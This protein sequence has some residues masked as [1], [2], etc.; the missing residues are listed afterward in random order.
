MALLDNY[1]KKQEKRDQTAAE[2]ERPTA[3]ELHRKALSI[4]G[5]LQ[6]YKW[7]EKDEDSQKK[8]VKD[9]ANERLG[10]GS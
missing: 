4:L 9:D 3:E 1:V 8:K 5:I 6:M 7:V 2:D 10:N